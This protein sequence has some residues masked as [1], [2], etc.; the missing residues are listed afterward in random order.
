M[1]FI[2]I[3]LG[4]IVCVDKI[5]SVESLSSYPIKRIVKAAKEEG[6][7]VD[8]TRGRTT[9]TVFITDTYIITSPLKPETIMR[10]IKD[11]TGQ[12]IGD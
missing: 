8:I 12:H 6:K 7:L 11:V 4:N 3:G 5:K 10:R 1:K 9:K 2:N